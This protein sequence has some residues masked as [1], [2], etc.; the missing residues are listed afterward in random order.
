MV[1]LAAGNLADVE[2]ADA[3]E[4]AQ[5]QQR[6]G[7]HVLAA[8]MFALLYEA[9]GTAVALLK[10]A[11]NLRHSGNLE[12]AEQAFDEFAA[13]FPTNHAHCMEA[14]ICK[15]EL[16]KFEPALALFERAYEHNRT[17]KAATWIGACLARQKR[18][19][20]ALEWLKKGMR[21]DPDFVTTKIEMANS[22]FHLGR[23]DDAAD[24]YQTVIGEFQEGS[25]RAL[26]EYA[27]FRF[28]E[29]F[30]R[31]GNLAKLAELVTEL[32]FWA[33]LTNPAYVA[34]ATRW[35]A[36]TGTTLPPPA[37]DELT[38]HIATN[39]KEQRSDERYRALLA[40]SSYGRDALAVTD[41]YTFTDLVS[42]LQSLDFADP[43]HCIAQLC[44]R[45]TDQQPTCL[46]RLGDGEGNFLAVRQNSSNQFL[47]RQ[48]DLILGIWF[49]RYAEKSPG[50]EQLY[51][52]IAM[53]L[54]SADF[55]GIPDVRRVNLELKNIPRGYWGVYFAIHQ[56]MFLELNFVVAGIH[57]L[58]LRSS[59][60][61][62]TL[63]SVKILNTISCHREFGRKL[64]TRLG[65]PDGLDL[66]VPGEMGLPQLPE[67]SRR[68]DHYRDH[69]SATM[70][71]IRTF[72]PGNVTL[73]GTGI[74]GK[75]YAYQ[76]K[77]AGGIG[78]D[79]GAMTD[80]FMGLATRPPFTDANFKKHYQWMA[81]DQAQSIA[82]ACP[83][84]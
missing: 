26:L 72:A 80:F 36:A 81:P 34:T 49:G 19:Q 60:F 38:L 59:A 74:C 51:Q 40:T 77:D 39:Q 27:Y 75:V 37:I 30:E 9:S 21:L 31:V 52:D 14:A 66:V 63:A 47:L 23:F 69:Y 42:R 17:G 82:L 67:E 68:G 54:L 12:H 4:F 57:Q 46:I 48:A 25:P 18:Y 16:R 6:K 8:A 29:C 71:A 33:Q 10:L 65:V 32:R 11:I 70:R 55:V 13:R 78:I 64:R 2:V 43:D 61:L 22:L 20:E 73:I 58:L 41:R 44:Q 79:I 53:A 56:A 84:T 45:I 83:D 7:H 50:Y 1:D 35:V 15:M 62:S 3:L 28:G 24:I 76:V 5:N